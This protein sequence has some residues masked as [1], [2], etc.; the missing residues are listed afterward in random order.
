M[1]V[2]GL[3]NG[4]KLSMENTARTFS[5]NIRDEKRDRTSH[6]LWP[7][8]ITGWG[9][10]DDNNG[11]D[12]ATDDESALLSLM[13]LSLMLLSLILLSLML[14]SLMLLSL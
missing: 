9:S 3:S 6:Q 1:D 7:A 5:G 8:I 10:D 13:L 4:P 2:A 11:N 12:G 14:L